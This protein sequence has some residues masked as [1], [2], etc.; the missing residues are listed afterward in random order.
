[1]LRIGL[2]G[3]IGSGKT[4][5]AELFARRGILV[6]DADAVA[7]RLAARGQPAFHHIVERFGKEILGADREIDRQRLR[8]RVFN[9]PHERRQLEAI[10]HPRVR[11]AM[12]Q[13]TE[14][15]HAP[16]CILAIP[17]LIEA[18]FLDLV[19]RVLVVDADEQLQIQRVMARN[20]MDA[21]AVKKILASQISRLQRLGHAHDCIVNDADLKHLEREVERLH[22]AYVALATGAN[23]QPG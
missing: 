13:E 10:L 15:L 21:E 18:G 12:H 6:I 2:T 7:R 20:N 16:Y 3:G 14:A 22:Q 9:N 8:A 4:T 17:L 11:A 5:V 23:K 1:M 19:D